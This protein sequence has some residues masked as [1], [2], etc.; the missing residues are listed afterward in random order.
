MRA[1][2]GALIS[3]A[4]AAGQPAAPVV[5]HVDHVMFTGGP[6]LSGLIGVL[7]DQF[8]LP[9]IFDGPSQTPPMPG[10]CVSFGNMCLEVVPLPPQSADA[11]PRR[12][13]IGNLALQA[14]DFAG[15]PLALRARNVEHFPVSK[16][17]RWTT[18][19][20]RGVGLGFLIE[21]DEGMPARQ[22]RF[23]R[24]L[25]ARQGGALGIVRVIEIAKASDQ[26]DELRPAWVRLLGEPAAGDR[27]LWRL[28]S[29][30]GLRLVDTH[31]PRANR[32]VVEVR[33]L[34]AA[35]AALR[36][37]KMLFAEGPEGLAIDS[38]ALFGFSLVLR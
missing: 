22:D 16:Q 3:L 15:A 24:E 20:L 34:D 9:V 17:A 27:D 33:D 2:A 1:L 13:G 32:I 35:R 10:T 14:V 4:L 25:D 8:Q 28:P 5:S 36:Q 11:A 37:M 23:R 30:I 29:G 26:I 12:A 6:E 19:G 31:D 18:I 7:R 21:Y 38:A